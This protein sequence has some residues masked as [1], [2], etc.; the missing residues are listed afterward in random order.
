MRKDP[1]ETGFT[2]VELMISLGLFAL[3]AVAGLAMVQ[4]ILN[5]QG[6]TENRL[7]RL[8]EVQRTMFVLT[9]DVDQI[10]HGRVEGDAVKGLTFTRAAPGIGGQPAQVHYSVVGGTLVREAGSTPQP[11]L[12]GVSRAQYRFFD[13]G[14]INK[15]PRNDEE[16]D[17]WPSAIEISM[18]VATPGG[19]PSGTLRRVITLPARVDEPRPPAFGNT[20]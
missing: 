10:A 13:H 12:A 4:G 1:A 11:L 19:G 18:Q 16:A 8:A 5:V 2:L 7:D 9:S 14:W 15:W 17:K 3:I 20:T 6:R